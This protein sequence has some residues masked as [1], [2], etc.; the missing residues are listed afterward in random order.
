MKTD[1]STIGLPYAVC[2]PHEQL[3]S[4]LSLLLARD[5]S[6]GYKPRRRSGSALPEKRFI[7]EQRK[8]FALNAHR[9]EQRKKFATVSSSSIVFVSPPS[10]DNTTLMLDAR[11]LSTPVR[12]LPTPLDF[13][14]TSNCPDS[15]PKIIPRSQII[16]LRL[17]KKIPHHLPPC[18]RPRFCAGTIRLRNAVQVNTDSGSP[19]CSRTKSGGAANTDTDSVWVPLLREEQL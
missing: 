6:L 13:I 10:P 3:L 4:R 1:T 7:V 17:Y 14:S 11:N 19:R 8:K 12:N 5:I 9:A 16:V 18:P 15:R 2:E